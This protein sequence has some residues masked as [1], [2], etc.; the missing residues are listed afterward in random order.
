MPSKKPVVFDRLFSYR[1]NSIDLR[2]SFE[3]FT[4]K[5]MDA[6]DWIDLSPALH[7]GFP[8][9]PGD[10]EPKFYK[11]STI[12]AGDGYNATAID[13]LAHVGSH[14]DAPLHFIDGGASID[15]APID[16]MI[17]DAKVIVIKNP[18]IIEPAE[19][20]E[21]EI[22]PGDRVLFK[23][24]NSDT[25]WTKENFRKK[26]VYLSTEACEYLVERRVKLICI[27]YLS[28]SG[29][30]INDEEAHLALLGAGIWLIE[31]VYAPGLQTGDYEMI[32]LPMNIKDADG[33][34]CRVLV[35]KK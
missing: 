24:K 9:W 35:R 20:R 28:V 1:K 21:H 30:K 34:P 8:F 31:G 4:R 10:K 25:D 2:E 23:T 5:E 6:K 17:G 26:F 15:R 19:L 32:C 7:T 11:I 13:S 16:V 29:Y 22:V 3:R 18:E 33:A 14:M 27:D 12:A